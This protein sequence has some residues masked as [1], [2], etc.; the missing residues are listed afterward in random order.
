MAEQAMLEHHR[1]LEEDRV[2]LKA[3]VGE[4]EGQAVV[5]AA[6]QRELEMKA[7][8]FV[9]RAERH[10]NRMQ[11]EAHQVAALGPMLDALVAELEDRTISAEPDGSWR[12]QDPSP[13]RAAG[14][15]WVKLEPA[16]R[17]LVGMVQAAED[18]RWTAASKDPEHTPLPCQDPTPYEAASHT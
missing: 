5:L 15:I 2:R 12:V 18:G 10:H 1:N 4:L 8:A 7:T 6:Q 3:Q 14:K 9:A 13:F 17:R 11:I 16:I